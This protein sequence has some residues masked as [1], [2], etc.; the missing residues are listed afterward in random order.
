MDRAEAHDLLWTK[1]LDASSRLHDL[2]RYLEHTQCYLHREQTYFRDEAH[3]DLEIEFLPLY[4]DTFPSI[5]H[6]SVI[7]SVVMLLEQE[8][9]ELA[10]ALIAAVDLRV[11]F[12][13]LA[14]SV[15]DRFRTLATKVVGLTIEDN[16]FQWADLVGLFELRNRIVH[17]TGSA[18]GLSAFSC[19]V[20]LRL[21]ARAFALGRWS[22]CADRQDFG[23]R[24]S[25]R[26]SISAGGLCLGSSTLPRPKHRLRHERTAT[27][28]AVGTTRC[29]G[30]PAIVLCVAPGG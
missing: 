20:D 18:I 28:G 24:R 17:S 8:V 25:N 2:E 23:G 12:N 29:I 13:D 19:G 22:G 7:V 10:G 4:R 26:V 1:Y 14:G 9:R 15:L 5:L 6:A 30:N 3:P 27:G 11:K 21:E 16:R